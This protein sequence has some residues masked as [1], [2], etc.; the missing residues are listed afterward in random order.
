MEGTKR[1]ARSGVWNLIGG[2]G[3]IY[4]RWALGQGPRARVDQEEQAPKSIYPC[5]RLHS[6][7]S[8]ANLKS[9]HR[10]GTEVEKRA[11]GGGKERQCSRC[12]GH[13]K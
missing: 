6:R 9:M 2:G 4:F 3:S 1:R 13:M 12:F 10:K 8:L 5:L 11:R 7:L